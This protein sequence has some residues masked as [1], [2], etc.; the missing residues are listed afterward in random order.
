MSRYTKVSML[1][2]FFIAV[3]LGAAYAEGVPIFALIKAGIFSTLVV[4][5]IFTGMIIREKY[6]KRSDTQ[7]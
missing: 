3:G 6:G 1:Y 7:W 5:G 2:F 4:A